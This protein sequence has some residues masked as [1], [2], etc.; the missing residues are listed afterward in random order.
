MDEEKK[1][2]K[3]TNAVEDRKKRRQ[4][5]C[6]KSNKLCV[7]SMYGGGDIQICTQSEKIN[8]QKN[9]RKLSSM[10]DN[11][12]SFWI[13]IHDTMCHWNFCYEKKKAQTQKKENI[14]Y[15]FRMMGNP[16]E[17]F[18]MNSGRRTSTKAQKSF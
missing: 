4:K 2:E 16:I 10:T 13:H 6:L 8:K 5:N 7:L 17:T 15:V 9:G 11:G 12:H 14:V 3:H 1:G 18:F